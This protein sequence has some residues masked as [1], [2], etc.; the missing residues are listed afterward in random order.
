MQEAQVRPLVRELRSHMLCSAAKKK[1]KRKKKWAGDCKGCFEEPSQAKGGVISSTNT[2]ST[3]THFLTP[4]SDQ[5]RG[6]AVNSSTEPLG[7]V[8]ELMHT[9]WPLLRTDPHLVQYLAP[10]RPDLWAPPLFLQDCKLNCLVLRTQNQSSDTFYSHCSLPPTP[11]LPLL[12]LKIRPQSPTSSEAERSAQKSPC[13]F[14]LPLSSWF[15]YQN[16]VYSQ[17]F[18]KRIS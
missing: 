15:I 12:A 4:P 17:L 10:L 11:C 7:L 3:R 6:A 2:P 9:S 18:L 13:S 16:H 5:G 14:F 1:E 8:W